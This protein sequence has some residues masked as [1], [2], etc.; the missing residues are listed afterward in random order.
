MRWRWTR[1]RRR[2]T[3]T[4]HYL[5]HREA[6]RAFVRERLEHFNAH[7]GFTYKRVAIKNQK[8]CWGSCSAKGNLN[9]SYKLLFLPPHLADY[10]I[11]HELCHLAELN[12]SPRF[13]GRVAERCPEYRT[14]R[15][16]LRSVTVRA[17]KVVPLRAAAPL[18]MSYEKTI[19]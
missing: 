12:H 15:R 18:F 3:P 14:C 11:V 9:F 13:W 8:S 19:A 10:V 4:K 5:A 2:R 16:E 17:G 1:I 7:Y 6:A